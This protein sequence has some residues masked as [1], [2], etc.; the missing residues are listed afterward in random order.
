M[1]H[2][3]EET[4][5]RPLF[6]WLAIVTG[7]IVFSFNVLPKLI[8]TTLLEPIK[9]NGQLIVVTRNS[10]TTY[11]EDADGP[12]GLE[13]ELAQMFADDSDG[14]MVPAEVRF[15][16]EAARVRC[17]GSG[18]GRSRESDRGMRGRT[19]VIAFRLWRERQGRQEIS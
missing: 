5:C 4:L 17:A 11:Y 8:H 7:G 13:Y 16:L 10:P 12:A 18:L 1:T 14:G 3:A 9:N 6:L 2:E 19:T 15:L